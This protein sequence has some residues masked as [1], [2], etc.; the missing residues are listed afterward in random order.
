MELD[1]IERGKEF[2]A[3]AFPNALPLIANEGWREVDPRD[4]NRIKCDRGH[5]CGEHARWA[6]Q[7]GPPFSYVCDYHRRVYEATGTF[8]KD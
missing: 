6:S 5:M 8:W 3:A 1:A 7:S 2:R 4:Q